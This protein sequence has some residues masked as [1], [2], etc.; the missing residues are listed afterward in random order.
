MIKEEKKR[1]K[2]NIV[3]TKSQILIEYLRTIF[4]SFLIATIL[5][6]FLALHARNEMIKDITNQHEQQNSLDRA[7]W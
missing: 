7:Y 3:K 4:C 1:S 5:T 2:Y 6:T